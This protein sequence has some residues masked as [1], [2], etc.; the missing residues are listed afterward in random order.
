MPAPEAVFVVVGGFGGCHVHVRAGV[1]NEPGVAGG[2][3][4]VP[5]DG[6]APGVGRRLFRE[7]EAVALVFDEGR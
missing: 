5:V 7:E 4:L 6:L 1:G 2:F 3:H